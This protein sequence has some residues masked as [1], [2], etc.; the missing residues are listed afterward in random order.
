MI[1]LLGTFCGTILINVMPAG[2]VQYVWDSN[3]TLSVTAGTIAPI[4]IPYTN[5]TISSWTVYPSNN[6]I[7]IDMTGL[8][9][10]QYLFSVTTTG[11]LTLQFV[12]KQPQTVSTLGT[13]TYQAGSEFIVY[14]AHITELL[15]I[16]YTSVT[17]QTGTGPGG[18]GGGGGPALCLTCVGGYLVSPQ[19]VPWLIA[20]VTLISIP[21]LVV[22]VVIER[23]KRK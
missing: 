23:R 9:I 10:R 19:G 12:G 1:I 4:S 20:V 17:C 6:T 11:L 21:L 15:C 8:E 5:Y 7:T 13:L 14:P 3:L 2:A 16:D 22:G 18:G